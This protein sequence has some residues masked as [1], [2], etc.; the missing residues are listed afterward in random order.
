VSDGLAGDLAKLARASGLSARVALADIP[1]SEAAQEAISLDPTL[2]DAAVS[3]GD[4]YEILC[5]AGS[6]GTRFAAAARASGA[7]C[8]RIGEL[9]AG[10]HETIFLDE[11]KKAKNFNILSFSHF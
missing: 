4:D 5:C 8:A 2:F 10:N 6:G 9:I 1:L 11:Q 7:P 3:G